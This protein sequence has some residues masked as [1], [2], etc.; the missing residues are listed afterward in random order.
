LTVDTPGV[1]NY[2][3][4]VLLMMIGFYAVFAENNLVKKV[5]GLGLFQTGIFLFYISIAAIEG[6]QAPIRNHNAAEGVNQVFVNPLPHV[7]ILTAIVVS[8]SV[9]A[10]ALAVVIHIQHQ[11]GTVEIDEIDAMDRSDWEMREHSGE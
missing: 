5:I 10:V 11:Y 8:V 7:L 3:I 4:C 2:V 6:G 9:M 1:F